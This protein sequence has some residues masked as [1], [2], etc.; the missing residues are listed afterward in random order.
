MHL[1]FLL[2]LVGFFNNKI[3]WFFFFLINKALCFIIHLKSF[4]E[5]NLFIQNTNI[6][7][8][9]IQCNHFQA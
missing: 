7:H 6:L 1:I 3:F 8:W 2:C 4:M 9:Q 5:E